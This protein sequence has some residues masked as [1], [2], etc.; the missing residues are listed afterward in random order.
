MTRCQK[1]HAL[2]DFS[3]ATLPR[4]TI[5]VFTRMLIVR[6]ETLSMLCFVVKSAQ[7]SKNMKELSKKKSQAVGDCFPLLL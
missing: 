6:N 2:N 7:S 5:E 3:G 1:W 4:D